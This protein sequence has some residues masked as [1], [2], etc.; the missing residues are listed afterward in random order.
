MNNQVIQ[1]Q[2][3][4]HENAQSRWVITFKIIAPEK[5]STQEYW[6]IEREIEK[7]IKDIQNL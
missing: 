5:I 2:V 4:Q 3:Y 7:T 1:E 6:K